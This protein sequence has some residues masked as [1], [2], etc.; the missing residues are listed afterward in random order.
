MYAKTWMKFINLINLSLAIVLF[1]RDAQETFNQ[2]KQEHYEY[3]EHNSVYK[4]SVERRRKLLNK[5]A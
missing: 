4:D 2:N 5:H 1:N 3:E